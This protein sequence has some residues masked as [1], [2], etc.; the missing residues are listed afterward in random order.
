MQIARISC[1][2]V[3]CPSGHFAL[4]DD[5][6]VEECDETPRPTTEE[7]RELTNWLHLWASLT[8]VSR[9]C[10]VLFPFRNPHLKRQGRCELHVREAPEGEEEGFELKEDER[11]EGPALLS[12]VD[13]DASSAESP[14]WTVIT[15][16]SLHN[17]PHQVA[18]TTISTV[19]STG[20]RV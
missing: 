3:L 18:N 16:S 13:Q 5:G 19:L 20:V 9:S 10:Q 1:A 7:L 14:P 8:P 17:Q 15:S 4:N 11:E 12:A 6:V 2:T